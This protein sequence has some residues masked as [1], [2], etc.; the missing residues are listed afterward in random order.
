MTTAEPISGRQKQAEY[1]F[2]PFTESEVDRFL[3]IATGVPWITDV[4]VDTPCQA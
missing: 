3:V 1:R 2:D 4:P